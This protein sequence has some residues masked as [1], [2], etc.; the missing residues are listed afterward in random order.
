MAEQTKEEQKEKFVCVKCG[1]EK[2]A[3][4]EGVVTWGDN[5]YCCNNCC[6]PAKGEIPG[7]KDNVCEFC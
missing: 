5:K 1:K 3:S 4:E 2:D 6:D 7:D